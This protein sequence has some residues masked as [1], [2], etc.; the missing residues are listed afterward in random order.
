M[1]PK[2][3]RM[4]LEFK[5]PSRGII[6]L[7]NSVLTATEGE[8]IIAHRFESFEPWKGEIKTRNNGALISMET[9]TAIP[10]AIFKL[11]DRGKFYINP[12]VEVYAGQVIGE[13]SRAGDLVVNVNKTKKL[14]NMRSSGSDDKVL[15]PPSIKFSLEEYMEIIRNDEYL[16]ITPRT[17][18]LRKIYLNEIERKRMSKR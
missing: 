1:E 6:G 14:S 8:A 12:N 7:R 15:I 13:N 2:N 16:E 18:R 10:F 4:M 3:D 5:I 9:G 11:I 17:L